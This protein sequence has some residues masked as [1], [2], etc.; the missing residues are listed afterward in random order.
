[1]SAT[2]GADGIVGNDDDVV[3]IKSGETCELTCKTGYCIAGTTQPSCVDGALSNGPGSVLCQRV[4]VSTCNFPP[5]GGSDPVVTCDDS[6]NLFGTKLVQCGACPHGYRSDSQYGSRRTC[7]SYGCSGGCHDIN[8]CT[9]SRSAPATGAR[10]ARTFL[11]ATAV[12]SAPVTPK[13]RLHITARL[14]ASHATFRA[15]QL[16]IGLDANQ[17]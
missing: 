17:A 4:P 14:G 15:R 16:E 3:T 1:V 11:A 12:G 10:L 9:E 5:N 6:T 13:A 2:A 7:N 8:E